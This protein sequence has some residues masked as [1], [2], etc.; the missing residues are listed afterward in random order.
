MLLA[1]LTNTTDITIGTPI[2][3]RTHPHLDNL[4]G[5]FVGTLVL[6][7]TVTPTH[8]FT[9]LLHH[10]RDTD[11]A[12][13]AHADLPFERL[14]ELLNPPRS[15]AHAPLTQVGFSFQNI[16]LPDFRLPG[17]SVTAEDLTPK[18]A[19]YDLHLSLIDHYDDNG[20]PAGVTAE[21]AYSTDLFEE[22]TVREFADRFL[23]ILEAVTRNPA[24]VTGDIDLLPASERELLVTRRNAT[25]TQWP[26]A[27]LPDLFSTQAAS[28]P[29]AVAIV[30]GDDRLTYREFSERVN[31]LGRHLITLGVGPESV[32]AL[33]S[34]RSTDLMVGI[35]AV[36][37]AGGAYLPVDSDHPME[38][39]RSVLAN[40]RPVALLS[41]EEVGLPGAEHLPVW[42][43][44]SFDLTGYD[45]GPITDSDRKAPLRSSHLAYLIYTSG[46]TGT[47]KGVAVPHAAVVNQMRW[48]QARYALD[49]ED[50]I[51]QKTPATF[52]LS[53]W[54]LFWPLTVGARLV[55]AA[56]GGHRDPDY[57]AR[58]M[59]EEQ[60]T[61]AD[62]VPS[63][64]AAF[65]DTAESADLRS[66]RQVMCIGEPFPAHT[67]ARLRR[68]SDAA[69]H[70]LYGPTEAAVSVTSYS[71]SGLDDGIVP[72]GTPES[73]VRCYV[74]DSR[75][76]PVPAGVVGE[77][78]LSGVQLAR[79]YQGRAALTAERFVP[80]PFGIPGRRMY[81]TGDF[82]RWA[83]GNGSNGNLEFLGRADDQLKVRGLR[84]EPGEIEAV[85][86]A[87]PAVERA[88]VLLRDRPDTPFTAG[89]V[90]AALVAYVVLEPAVADH[91]GNPDFA[92]LRAEIRRF[93][94]GRVPE[95]MVPVAVLVVEQFP[96]TANGKLD[97]SRLPIPDLSG[98]H[99]YR[100]PRTADEQTLV[101]L[102]TEV[103]GVDGI[104]IDD[105]FFELG[106]HSLLATRLVNRIRSTLA[107]EVP[108]RAIFE[109]PA[110]VDLATQLS[111]AEPVR[112]PLVPQNRADRVPLSYAQRRLWFLHR[113]EGPSATYNIALAVRLSGAIDCDA[114]VASLH[115]VVIRHESL[116]TIFAQ[117]D[118]VPVQQVLGV[119]EFELHVDIVSAGADEL[120]RGLAEVSRR[121]F[122]LTHEIPLHA[123]IFQCADDEC[124][125]A[126]V[127]HH[128]AGDGGSLA[129]LARDVLR[130]YSARR[131]G[132]APEW[133]PLRVQYADYT[134][135][136]RSLLGDENDPD[137]VM[138]R[139]FRYWREALS[140]LPECL[141]LPTDRP[142]PPVASY[143]GDTVP[144][145]IEASLR[146]SVEQLARSLG[147]TTSM[148]LQA[149]LAVLLRK[150]GC[151][152]DIPL[153]SPIA[154]R[155]D[156]ALADLVGYLANT[157]V[158]RV[159]LSGNPT[160]TDLID[161]VRERALSAYANQDAPFEQLVEMMNPARSTGYHPL[162]QVCIALQN[163][164]LPTV[165]IPGVAVAPE[166][167]PTGTAKFDLFV[168]LSDMSGESPHDSGFGG[169]IEYATDLFDASTVETIAVRYVRVLEL[170][171]AGP[172]H[173]VD[174]LDLLGADE[175]RQVLE[176][177]ND[178]A[179]PTPD[180]TI[181]ELF[182]RQARRTADA[183]AVVCE[184]H[185]LTYR[186]VELRAE[187]LTRR[188]AERAVGPESVVAVALP[189]SADL[190]IA[191]LAVLGS[192]AAYLPIDPNYSSERTGRIL[193][194]ARPCL[195]LT[196]PG[197]QEVLHSAL[198]RLYVNAA[199]SGDDR[200]AV[201]GPRPDN[202]AY[203]VYTS[204]STGVP[205]G[206]AVSH[207]NVTRCVLQMASRL[208]VR[209]GSRVVAS[210]SAGF[211]V[212]VFEIF[213]PL[214]SGGSIEVVRDALVLGE[215][216]GRAADVISAAP[217]AL[218]EVV[219][220][221]AETTP[222]D[223]I[224]FAGEALPRWLVDR[225]G[226]VM[227]DVRILNAYG[228]TEAAVYAT[229]TEV[230]PGVG[231]VPIGSPIANAKAYVLDAG[232]M[233]V[234]VGVVGELWIAGEGVVRGYYRRPA[235]TA[236]RFV[237]DPFGKQGTR[238]Y[239]SGD[240]VRWN[241]SGVLEFVGRADEQIKIRGFRVEPAEIEATFLS[242]P[243]VA[244]AAVIARDNGRGG[245]L[246]SI[247]L[248]SYVVLE[249]VSRARDEAIDAELVGQWQ[250]VYDDLYSEGESPSDDG[251]SPEFGEEF[252]I[253]Q[254]R[255]TGESIPIE[256]MREW[257]DATVERIRALR[258]R[259]ILEIGVGSGL[260]LSR[261]APDAVEYWATD[262]SPVTI[263]SLR[264][265]LGQQRG[266]S[267]TERVHLLA[268]PADVVDGLPRDGFDTIVVNSVVQYFPDAAYLIDVIEQA[269]ELLEPGGSIFVG[270]VRNLALQP[271]F[272]IGIQ[273][274][275]P[276]GE[277]DL[278]VV[279]EKVRRE[280]TAESEL[281]L[282]PEFFTALPAECPGIGGVDI[283]LERGRFDNELTR[284]RYNVVL[285]KSPVSS[286]SL[287]EVPSRH[288]STIG[289]LA[290]LKEF[291]CRSWP[292]HV[293]VVGIPQFG[294]APDA[295]LARA[296]RNTAPL[297][298]FGAE[299]GTAE[300]RGVT[301]E[302]LH[303]LGAQ[304]G[305]A[306]AVTWGAETG[307]LDAVFVNEGDPPI[308]MT[309]VFTPP[310]VL[311][312]AVEY[313][314]D[315]RTQARLAEVREF[316]SERLPG[317]MVPASMTALDSLPLTVN[318]KL[319][320]RALPDDVLGSTKDFVTPRTQVE[321]TI[322][323]AFGDVLGVAS[324]GVDDDFF[325]LGGNSLI[326]ARLVARLGPALGVS[327]GVR[328]LF[329][330]PTVAELATRLADA[331]SRH[332]IPLEPRERPERIPLS[333]AQRRMWFINQFD[334]DSGAYNIPFAARLTGT[335]DVTALQAAIGDVLERH[336]SLRTRF[337]GGDRGPAQLIV[338]A[339][340][341]LAGLDLT[342]VNV[343]G[344]SELRARIV[345][346][347]GAGFD[348]AED[349]PIRIRLFR[350][351]DHEHVLTV[352]V[353]HISADGASMAP[354]AR[355][356]MA[357]YEARAHGVAPSWSPLPVQYADYTLWQREV[358][359]SEE[360]PDSV[361]GRQLD[362]WVRTLTGLPDVIDLPVDRPRRPLS[363][364]RADT[365]D[366]TLD[367]RL[368]RRITAL[369]HRHH[370]TVFMVM[371]AALAALL[372]R[373]GGNRDIAVGTPVAG[374]GERALDD[375][376]GMLVNTLVLRSRVEPSET[377]ADLLART[378]EGDLA[379]FENADVPFERLVEVLAP[380]R[381]MSHSPLF[382][383]MLTVQNMERP[384]LELPNLT[385]EVLDTPLTGAKVD[386]TVTLTENAEPGSPGM[387][388]EFSY[389]T[390]YFDR[391]TIREVAAQYVRVLESVSTD[392][393]TPI[394]DVDLLGETDTKLLVPVFAETDAVPRVLPDLLRDHDPAAPA[395]VFEG[396]TLSYGELDVR[397]N[398]LAR[399]LICAGAAPESVVAIAL[400]RS[401]EL[402]LAVWAVTKAGAAFLPVDP[403]LPKARIE[404]MLSDSGATLGVTTGTDRDR[405][406][407]SA[408]WLAID[409]PDVDEALSR[410]SAAP[411]SDRERVSRLRLDNTAYVIYTSGS[412]GTPKGVTV[413]HRGLAQLAAE[414]RRRFAV[415]PSARVL[416]VA[417]PSFDGSMLELLMAVGAGAALV[418]APPAV[419]G[420]AE[421][422]T[423]VTDEHVTHAF[424]TTAVVSA[425]DPSSLP[426]LGVLVFGGERCTP[427]LIER[428]APG[429]TLI[430]LY[431]PTETTVLATG[432]EPLEPGT[433][434]TIGDPFR[435]M[436]AVVLDSRLHPVPIGVP[437]ELYL[438]GAQLARGYNARPGLTSQRFVADPCGGAGERMYRTGDTVRWTRGSGGV[439]LEFLGRND[440]QVKLRGLRVELGEVESALTSHP[441]IEQAVTVG[442][443]GAAG[444]TV[445]ASYVVPAAGADPDIDELSRFLG[446][447]LPG[448]MVP[449]VITVLSAMPLTSTGKVDR[450]AL[451]EHK[452]V[453]APA[454]FVA[455]RNPTE[456]TIAALFAETL[457]LEHVG[458]RESFFALGGDS[459]L[460]IQLVSRLRSAGIAVSARDIFECK[461]VELLTG[462]AEL[463]RPRRETLEELDGGGVGAVT[464][465][466]IVRWFLG[467][468]GSHSRFAQS[469]LLT[470]PAGATSAGIERTVQIVLDH[471][472]MLRARFTLDDRAC[473]VLAP[474]TIAATDAVIGVEFDDAHS[475][476]T[477]G[478]T[479][480]V[481]EELA[482]ATRRLDPSFGR[483]IQVVWLHPESG[484][485]GDGRVLVVI[486]H[487]VV[488]AVSWRIL[489]PDFMSA[490]AQDAAGRS[491]SL[492]P[493]GTSMRRWAAALPELARTRSD[494]AGFWEAALSVPDPPLGAV[495]G[496]QRT[497]DRIT[498]V[499]PPHVTE[500]LLTTL[501][502]AIRGK[503]GDGLLTA[504]ALAVQ[505][506][507]A[508][509]GVDVR[510]TLVQLEGHG[511]EEGLVPGA[512]L[513]RTVGWFTSAFPVHLDL[514]GLDGASALGGGPATVRAV[515]RV[516]ECLRRV[517]DN[518][519]GY[520]LLRYL[521]EERRRLEHFD[522]PQISFNYLG[523][524]GRG[525]LPEGLDSVGWTPAA[526]EFDPGAAGDQDI[527]VAG[528]LAITAYTAT[529]RFGGCLTADF[530][531]ASNVLSR[532]EVSELAELWTCALGA[533]AETVLAGTEWGLT[534]SDVPLV[535]IAQAELDALVERYPGAIDLWPLAL[536]Q[537]GLLFHADLAHHD[538]DVYTAQAVL[539]L[540]GEVDGDRLS[541][542]STA[543]L[544]RHP[545]LRTAFLRRDD[546]TPIQV[547][548]GRTTP[549]LSTA[550]LTH[551]DAPAASAEADRLAAAARFDRFD[552][553]EPPL[554]RLL[555]VT[556]ASGQHRLVVTAHHIL[557]DGWS[558]PIMLRELIMLYVIDGGAA[559]LP[560]ARPFSDYLTW[561]AARDRDAG[562]DVW[563]QA[564]ADVTE[565]SLL[566]P[567]RGSTT[568]VP[569]EVRVDV[570]EET[571]ARLVTFTRTSDVT[572]STVVQFAWAVVL[573]NLLGRDQVVFGETVS[574]RPPGLPGI[575]SMVGLF[576][577][578][579]PVSV[580]LD[581]RR[582]IADS[583]AT[584]QSRKTQLLEHHWVG[585]PDIADAVG[586]GTLFDT[587]TVFESYPVDT[588]GMD[589]ETD[590]AG[591][592]VVSATGS[593]SA[594][595]PLTIQAHLDDRLHVRVRYLPDSVDAA[596]A[597][598][599]ANRLDKVLRAVVERPGTT[600]AA[601]GLLDESDRALTSAT[602][603]PAET[604]RTLP[605]ILMSTAARNPRAVALE[606]D[607]ETLS[608]G[609]LDRRSNQLARSLIAMGA[610]PETMVAVVLP[611]SA[612]FSV[613][614]WAA[615]K[616]GAAFTPM[617]PNLPR[618]RV[619]RMLAD[620]LSVVGITTSEHRAAVPDRASWLLLDDPETNADVAA[621]PV[622]AIAEGDRIRPSRIDQ[623]AY[624]IYTSGSTGLPKG[625]VVTH[626]GL[627]NFAAEQRDRYSV[628][629]SSRVLQVAA[630][631][632][633]ATMLE[634]LMAY[635]T[636]ATLVVS[637][638]E[639]FAGAEL[640][641][642]ISRTRVSHAF[643][644]PSVLATMRPAGMEG[645]EVLVAGGE[646][647]PTDLVEKWAP[648]RRL[649]N[650]YGPTETVIMVAIS[651]A[652]GGGA[653]VTIGGPIRGVTTAV[654][655]HW[656]RPVPIGAAGE[657]YVSGVQLARGYLDQP[658]L[659]AQRFVA[660]P[661]GPAGS[662]LY[663]TGDIVRRN[664][665]G[666]LEYLSRSDFQIKVRG[667]RIE[668]GEIDSVLA[669]Y[670]GV[671]VC[672]TV[673]TQ[674]PAG[675]TALVSYIV[676][677]AG[678]VPDPAA[679]SDH[680][681]RALPSYMVP[682]SIVV[683]DS[684]PLTAT[685]KL[686]REALPTPLPA[687]NRSFVAPR[688]PTEDVVA[689]A[690]ARALGVERVGAH[691]DFFQ[692]GGNSLSAVR[693]TARIGDAFG[694][695]IGVRDLFEAP[696]VAELAARV[697][698]LD[699]GSRVPLEPQE[700]PDRVPLSLAQ[701]RMWFLNQ[702]D[703]S[704][705]AYN[706][707]MVVRLRGKLDLDAL[708][709]AVADLVARHEVLR[710]VYPTADGE[711]HQVVLPTD[712][713]VPQIAPSRVDEATLQARI[714]EST[715]AGFDVSRSVPIRVDVL[716]VGPADHVVVLTVHHISADG[717]SMA[718]LIRDMM[719]AY[720]ARIAQLAPAWD[721]L[722]V[723]YADYT[724]WQRRM[725][726][727]HTDPESVMSEQIRYWTRELAGLPDAIALPTDRPRPAVATMRGDSV[728]FTVPPDLQDRIGEL[729]RE[730][731]TS[732]FMVAH[733][734]LSVLLARLCGS[735]DI[736]VGTPVAGR[737]DRALDGLAGMFVN[738]LV[739][740]TRVELGRPFTDLLAATR[741]RDL[742][743]FAHSDV[744]FEQLVEVLNP[745]RTTAHSPLFQVFFAFQNIEQATLELPGLSV[746]PLVPGSRP[747]MFDL[748]LI[749]VEH[750]TA[751]GVPA[752]IDGQFSYATDL[753]DSATVASF[754]NRFTRILEAVTADSAT[755]AG[756]VE[757]LDTSE[758]S[759]LLDGWNETSQPLDVDAGASLVS[760]I[761]AQVARTPDRIAILS[762]NRSLTFRQFDARVNRLARKLIGA[763]VGP[764]ST[765]G[766]GIRRSVDL[767]VAVHAVV[768][769]G[770]AYVPID[771]D[772]PTERNAY[773]LDTAAPVCVLTT[774]RDGFQFPG[775]H[776]VVCVDT[777]DL[778]GFDESP[779]SDTDRLSSVRPDTAAYVVFT[780]G[781]TGRPKGVAVT[782]SSLVNQVLWLA[783]RFA[784]SRDD[785]V[786]LK[787]PFTF[788]VS[789][790]ELFCPL[791]TGARV[792]VADADGHRD[793]E[794]LARVIDEQGVSLVSFV[795]SMLSVFV[796]GL[797]AGRCGSLRAVLV[798]GEELPARTVE[799]VRIGLPGASVHNLYGP[800]EFTV[801]AT[802][803]A[804]DGEQDS[805]VPIGSP[806]WNASAYVLDSRLR[807]VPVGVPGELY[808]AGVQTARGY[809]GRPELT[810]DRFVA[811][812]YGA[813]G[814]RMYRTGDL[815]AWRADGRLVYLGRTDFQVKLR[816]QRI[817]LGEIESALLS[818][819]SVAGAVVVVHGDE[820]TG[821]RLVAYVVPVAGAVI[822]VDTVRDAVARDVPSYMVPSA[823]VV[824]DEL[825]VTANGKLDRK[826]LPAPVFGT[827]TFREP[828]TALEEIVAN[829]FATVLGV[830]RVGATDS[831]FEL[832]GTSL[833]AT[834]AVSEL[835]SHSGLE[836]PLQWM[837]ADPTPA[838]IARRV[839]ARAAGESVSGFEIVTP[840]RAAGSEPPLFGIHPAGGLAWFYGGLVSSLDAD[841]PLYG[842]QDPH[843]VAGEPHA[844]SVEE[845][846]ARYVVEIRRV[847]PH[848]PYHLLGWSLGGDIA[849]AIA[850]R[851]QDAGDEVGLLAILDSAIGSAE[852]LEALLPREADTGHPV[853]DLL[854]GW[855]ELLDL[856]ADAKA[857][858]REDVIASI[859]TQ[860]IA[861]GLVTADRVDR[862]M[863]SFTASE[864]LAY[865]YRPRVFR[866]D[867]A[868]FTAGRGRVDKNAAART[869]E[870]YASGAV[871]NTV[872][873]VGHLE[874]THPE[875]L[876]VIGPAL[877]L[878]LRRL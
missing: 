125:L 41:S 563:R 854:G 330:A 497:V 177:W 488:D 364:L 92:D 55:L 621:Q 396:T 714:V 836:V 358:L 170:F 220:R 771:P 135:W 723:Q 36:L 623:P 718:P 251:E 371:H 607:G 781:S 104:G 105:G 214:C 369:A 491:V 732:V 821:D 350:V 215:G 755:A 368:H 831:F 13:F 587:L 193:A 286:R 441:L 766:I 684:L 448:Y 606:S 555:L 90:D 280:M 543:L 592:R 594:H 510:G 512:D 843:V 52:D 250:Q 805:A 72:I 708:R 687:S 6:R 81:R 652:L 752:G 198:P 416:Q 257:R 550:D 91:A 27:T 179:E 372:A 275:R 658:A 719:T 112:Q 519:I 536:L 61:T 855:R 419:F 529:T 219:D 203:L 167:A 201:S 633:D 450:T 530:R 26:D 875:A 363:S 575:E 465:T 359:G 541:R 84:I 317:Y 827:R 467:L 857:T 390:D 146:R 420:G 784:L 289:D 799:R 662:R 438:S 716:E 119:D 859:R 150:L 713:A 22:S 253:W 433:P 763:G 64:L 856:G 341:V 790:W 152:T 428:W 223:T 239:R 50:S 820:H 366:F 314:N 202:L 768:K 62:F 853:A 782:H 287:A 842:V 660:N 689:D 581:P 431:G 748:S 137:S 649:Y 375:L 666:A 397:S 48:K 849:H 717:S 245:D 216:S 775:N 172:H 506:W 638:P 481:E 757:I 804:V 63:L 700:R 88:V 249:R 156:E 235:L 254:S 514:D 79:G 145:I 576:I 335:L 588:A 421:L 613:A 487:L 565:P 443:K 51:L 744:P 42:L 493:V 180:S 332:H 720:S 698:N 833:L 725:L 5:M 230:G 130:A 258:P 31:R 131:D 154:G 646:N 71:W 759:L 351:S 408:D 348:V 148:V 111:G 153:G 844:E 99:P 531:F 19:K 602:G 600:L 347:I 331:E 675:T 243:A 773:V 232:L 762:G 147:A 767:V 578:T 116:R 460:S 136:Q 236:E 750:F 785:V 829:G 310:P 423:L 57:L 598:S 502:H 381:E 654:L 246:S 835:N 58:V 370:T 171:V 181:P 496:T 504:L 846:A 383:V 746:E 415:T 461:T 647:V 517:P 10:I 418:V 495:T 603:G 86:L 657:L 240:L 429:R 300:P 208:G 679:L 345:S 542:A 570:D 573:G 631:S 17:I 410:E 691:D 538:L 871:T 489:I 386:L 483:M 276:D 269:L 585:L 806:V 255:F 405:L 37:A 870:K 67:A 346:W 532:G 409:D 582:T 89:H 262:L 818:D 779:V 546:G 667:L 822:D 87:H 751:D 14:V 115:D 426:D 362:F 745:S 100:A 49:T 794:Y 593:D 186:E 470:L 323:T 596:T 221:L 533:I 252:G 360:D 334:P 611:R 641:Q 599:I 98:A 400:G 553:T 68:V 728:E 816:G 624:V 583:L 183:V 272:A 318:G 302:E 225:V 619:E 615:A 102:Y 579:V 301:A 477:I 789:V 499:L 609:E 791:I 614:M 200:C 558:L 338:G 337:P 78:Y 107:V 501:P 339:A 770:G 447:S 490:W 413:T 756:D 837:F 329:E 176:T 259:R 625:V 839:E 399:H 676:P 683:L 15:T 793:P 340:D 392:P 455:P 336:E 554:L 655:D 704:S 830:D 627:A 669:G 138:G 797:G 308:P 85:L 459:I 802:E 283:Q 474:G 516:K 617:D 703:T 792:V 294:V 222:P 668:L 343:E 736:A 124:V 274:S 277:S 140:G 290:T 114:L 305:L 661:F 803:C 8:T 425:M 534:P 734:A 161:A 473:E 640:Q 735:A 743:A 143:R 446:R 25:D 93:V 747:A 476:G 157:W 741:E 494:E 403:G 43:I 765:V 451:S 778:S 134:L 168:N 537:T 207:R 810:A 449:T 564:L 645:L 35:Y 231:A 479:R 95:Y 144:F 712:R 670:P 238:M 281:L 869:W 552:M 227:P 863:D 352:V 580:R 629:S 122:D 858:T 559:A 727:S 860:L 648:H 266:A 174:L 769:A 188:L 811:N 247:Q 160:V 526:E 630:P 395:L 312:S 307:H 758:R 101:E 780:S 398:R 229:S 690:Y 486:H 218:T 212:S 133:T 237:A 118:G 864:R 141:E 540:T 75:L 478:F 126:L 402:W 774:E 295:A 458:I 695:A 539:G 813:E 349:V 355:D 709:L 463:D 373:L 492:T 620:G 38:R 632:F 271:A 671:G 783:G 205:K 454:E 545:N 293:R 699:A 439:G 566:A 296:L 228:P 872:V 184:N 749:L 650:G 226:T 801:H 861:S 795:P 584:L 4:I 321:R 12:A 422:A 110:I 711:P 715:S 129:P 189:R 77:L 434:I 544:D 388:G 825:P 610:G 826:A 568:A 192:G 394:G 356:V 832:G 178:T 319:D 260:L 430:N 808:L 841:R 16:A 522:E 163:N 315:P 828:S 817:E 507:R 199:E 233:P 211:D 241:R 475:P 53:V 705:P 367:G 706:I 169:F 298:E 710:T 23:L 505:S 739:L 285:R 120:A 121:R 45:P 242:H 324:V 284:Y 311:R 224:V 427:E 82:V 313:A 469:M 528:T 680:A 267:W 103:L 59:R 445:L 464:A 109:F 738:T 848:G 591:L 809:V 94:A 867:I 547:V 376:V 379:A 128:I 562:L 456:E 299:Q 173:R 726:G 503:A 278:A 878:R 724:L 165:D 159:D 636:G 571:T 270:D 374:R 866:G 814:D 569:D 435:G 590:L 692:L 34:K 527:A 482:A 850:V 557:V 268:Q 234:P 737:S 24:V 297:D 209:E 206:V 663:R 682:T 139:Q 693:V 560:P 56:P 694:I 521:G 862:I 868:F 444:N 73:N 316:V 1:R 76:N 852:D 39:T 378:R 472:D 326:A 30:S 385:L 626:R 195:A 273:R 643:I 96:L 80:D 424:L 217:S 740:R 761:D 561:L 484:T 786:L 523:R 635:G 117:V 525:D 123:R 33:S 244:Q 642:L 677:A 616:T 498:V 190:V 97:G 865:A 46:S 279:R 485:A 549:G 417:S 382:Q 511:R 686:D 328:E 754:A 264:R 158:L 322:A 325:E 127:I 60:I 65:L 74:C 194:E 164:A 586:L 597:R 440:F 873:D 721:P 18:T 733:A 248:S 577:N 411:I 155:T 672:V 108:I 500:A 197:V 722:P 265:R 3:G 40:A 612:A 468:P 651:D 166:P 685:G 263:E 204:G 877:N 462:V 196:E 796:D 800:T 393:S 309:D 622:L 807:P 659:T 601:I 628:T 634:M 432:S 845:L 851:L 556:T 69:V 291:L 874:M 664:A 9:N 812:H 760:L 442:A 567:S 876:A 391:S 44:E 377:F 142:R 838:A 132:R 707:P 678:A 407:A 66:L 574:G 380:E 772:Q 729:A 20:D 357:A 518:G 787:T 361:I 513:S 2:A 149:A 261:L 210:T 162:F 320:K 11:I 524:D 406:P 175:R 535:R 365:V 639:I 764:E 387:S 653:P 412:T 333:P 824:L 819:A 187:H 304:L 508:Q 509:R 697:A 83:T 674:N 453:A 777:V 54:E 384:H 353:H 847:Q 70:N 823:F 702:F 404:H 776:S 292:E 480:I 742:T 414:E 344:S 191:L 656:L 788:D 306:V 730:H 288:W 798:A 256:Q 7:T 673:G 113:F 471:H 342:P 520:G 457:G 354:L 282:R 466:P 618:G 452:I 551:L 515:A 840:L 604:P 731:R 213:A 665:D 389:A 637:P 608:Y 701:R 681:R 688:T 834:R 696:A 589:S 753:F 185:Q 21:L 644:T 605:D 327:V 29:H 47:P 303:S 437:G 436:G 595:Y 182:R 548:V 815:V 32:V 106:G 401:V 572:A 28:T 151:G